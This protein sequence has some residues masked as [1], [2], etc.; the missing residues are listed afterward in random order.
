[1]KPRVRAQLH[2]SSARSSKILKDYTQIETGVEV[3]GVG[4]LV[5]DVDSAGSPIDTDH[6]H[7]LKHLREALQAHH[8]AFEKLES[9]LLE[10]EQSISEEATLRPKQEGRRGVQ[11]LS[12]PQLRQE[13]GMG[14]S[15][16]YRRLRS[17]EI[18]SIRLGRT[19]KVRRDEL[20]EYLQRHHYAP[21][22]EAQ[23]E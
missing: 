23:E 8:Q 9:A 2:S 18:P 20:E 17:G 13:L 12:I 7:S 11:L 5:L 3:E 14:K 6:E 21:R 1:M 10:F 4:R 19:I 22:R 15:W 16:I